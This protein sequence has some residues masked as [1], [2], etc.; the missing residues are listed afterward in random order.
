MQYVRFTSI[1]YK[2]V[3]PPY[4][5]AETYAGSVTCCPLVSHVE[6]APRALLR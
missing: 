2:Y 1:L 3:G 5:Q 4:Y 6:Y